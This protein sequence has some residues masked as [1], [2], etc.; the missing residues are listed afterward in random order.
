MDLRNL[1][2]AV[3][4]R[5]NLHC[6]YCYLAAQSHG[7]DMESTV[8]A[9]AL[10][11]LPHSGPCH[12]QISGG[13]PTLVPDLIEQ[14]GERCRAINTDISLAIQTN[15]TL[16][17][18]ELIQLFTTFSIEVGVSLDGIPAI[19]NSLRGKADDTL[20]S[21]HLLELHNIPFRVTTVVSADNVEHL[22]TLVLMLSG[23]SLCRGIGLDLLVNKGRGQALTPPLAENLHRGITNLV[24]MF[25]KVNNRRTTPIQLR[26]LDMCHHGRSNRIFCRATAGQSLAVTPDGSLYPCSQTMYDSSFAMG[27]VFA[28]DIYK[29][30]PLTAIN[31]VSK[32]CN[33]CQLNQ[34]CPGDCPS[35]IYYGNTENPLACIMYQAIY[36]SRIHYD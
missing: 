36:A 33:D 27:T 30:Q 13:E 15:G 17:T 5:C 21:L 8:L 9:N 18:H 20:R 19:H 28:P 25:E 12:V 1:I 3:T 22:D 6:K 10:A 35:R 26:E 16:L 32:E 14:V 31:L 23:F 29:K 2:L 11:L 34:Q 24:Q 7:N 4:C